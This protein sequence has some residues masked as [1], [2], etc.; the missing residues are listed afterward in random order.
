MWRSRLRA[1]VRPEEL[2]SGPGR[3]VCS[4]GGL[5]VRLTGAGHGDDPHAHPQK[6]RWRRPRRPT[7]QKLTRPQ[8]GREPAIRDNRDEPGVREEGS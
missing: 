3:D 7:R 6:N 4:A 8:K 1:S 5:P 2:K